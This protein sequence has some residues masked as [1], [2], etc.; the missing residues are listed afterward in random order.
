[1]EPQQAQAGQQ[2]AQNKMVVDGAISSLM[3][4]ANLM[5]QMLSSVVQGNATIAAQNAE[6]EKLKGQLAAQTAQLASQAEQLAAL[7]PKL[8]EQTIQ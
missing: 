3:D 8:V 7:A 4:T 2:E 1:M 6:I 5:R